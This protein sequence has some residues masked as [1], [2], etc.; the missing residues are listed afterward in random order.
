MVHF[1]GV[2]GALGG[3][4]CHS[5]VDFLLAEF[6]LPIPVDFIEHISAVCLLYSLNPNL[7]IDDLRKLLRLGQINAVS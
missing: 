2:A 4:A 1:V 3:V 6:D 7:P 5:G